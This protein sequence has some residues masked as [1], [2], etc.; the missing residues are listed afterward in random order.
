M[1]QRY[2]T[3]YSA[4]LEWL[5]IAVRELG[6]HSDRLNAINVFP[7][8]DGDTGSNMYRTA[9][10]ALDEVEARPESKD[11]GALL[12]VAG[13]AGLEAAHG[14]S[15]TLLAVVLVG[16]GEALDGEHNLTAENFAKALDTARVRAWSALSEPV[17]GTML[18]VL[19]SAAQA[20]ARTVARAEGEQGRALLG[21]SLVEA[22][23]AAYGA[24]LA[25]TEQLD[26]LAAAR[27][28]DAGAVGLYLFMDA[29]FCAVTGREFDDEDYEPL[30]GYG[31]GD[32]EI[33][34]HAPQEEGVEVMCTVTA[35]PLDAA[36]L[37]ATLD[38]VGDSV[39]MTP[40]NPVGEAFRWRIHVHV[41]EAGTALDAVGRYGEPGEV[42]VT[43]LCTHEDA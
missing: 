7:V 13:R 33:A 2:R 4:V 19:E 10:A 30:Q 37:R 21:H 41:P 34:S 40:V 6:N 26:Q 29:L 43:S 22:R 14:N 16:A 42:S 24:V 36:T 9:R 20:A 15:G 8:A 23:R 11:L 5:R 17:P 35:T 18:S 12:T 39:V 1:T 3:G 32:P 25:T 28:V 31:I 27:V 38:S